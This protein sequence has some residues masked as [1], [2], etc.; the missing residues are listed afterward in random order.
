MPRD[1]TD[2]RPPQENEPPEPEET[3]EAAQRAQAFAR[4]VEYNVAGADNWI[5]AKILRT[6]AVSALIGA[7]LHWLIPAWWPLAAALM[8]I[9]VAAPTAQTRL[10]GR[11][12]PP[13]GWTIEAG[14][15]TASPA[16]RLPP[17]LVAAADEAR[18]YIAH[19]RWRWPGVFVVCP[20][21]TH[22]SN[23]AQCT[24]CA[25]TGVSAG[26]FGPWVI[27]AIGRNTP[28]VERPLEEARAV[29]IHESVHVRGWQPIALAMLQPIRIMAP[30]LATWIAAP[31]WAV[32]AL[33]AVYL[34]FIGVRW[35]AELAA[36]LRSA[37]HVDPNAQAAFLEYRPNRLRGNGRPP[38]LARAAAHALPFHPPA[39]LR[40]RIMRSAL[41]RR[42]YRAWAAA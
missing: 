13:P 35:A 34:A 10:A 41:A 4:V 23:P 22:T 18:A 5:Q 30:G 40:A 28:L 32:P 14:K 3:D 39:R 6:M 11:R 17:H 33:A 37:R 26:P 29:L 25:C 42:L 2:E 8:V 24:D 36:D 1:A 9:Q 31:P 38:W 7:S 16:E 20:E 19:S 12:K 15:H 21:C 27:I